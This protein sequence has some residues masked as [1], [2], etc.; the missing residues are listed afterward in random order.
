MDEKLKSAIERIKE[1]CRN[2]EILGTN[3]TKDNDFKI[4]SEALTAQDV[5]A[6]LLEACNTVLDWLNEPILHSK[7]VGG[8]DRA[9]AVLYRAIARAEQKVQQP[10]PHK[11]DGDGERCSKC[12]DKDWM[13][14]DSCS[15]R[16][17]HAEQKGGQ[18]D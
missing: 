16:K 1:N 18:N 11:W 5:N 10:V 14:D 3:K 6:E 17:L 9:K 7:D 12:G 2:Y 8:M 15:E 4:L 13:A